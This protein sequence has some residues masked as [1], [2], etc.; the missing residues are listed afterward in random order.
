[1]SQLKLKKQKRAGAGNFVF[2]K[3][4]PAEPLSSNTAG[5][6]IAALPP[7]HI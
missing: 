4:N 6:R 1:L 3:S 5:G 2:K 7:P